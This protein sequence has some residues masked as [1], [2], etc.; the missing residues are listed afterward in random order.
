ML[1][2]L[3]GSLLTAWV[4]GEKLYNIYSGLKFRNATDNPLFF[5]A[6]L[7]IVVGSQL[8]LAGFLGELF[9]KQSVSK[10]SEY[11][12]AEKTGE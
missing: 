2:F 8:F 11:S 4:I 3:L 1:M 7:A 9:V 12:I 5:L 6:L 10:T